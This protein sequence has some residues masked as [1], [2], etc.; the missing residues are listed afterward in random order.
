MQGPLLGR[1][2]EGGGRN[3]SAVIPS[4]LYGL[5]DA[6]GQPGAGLQTDKCDGRR[7]VCVCE[8]NVA[9]HHC[10]SEREKKGRGRTALGTNTRSRSWD[11]GSTTSSNKG[12]AG[13]ANRWAGLPAS[14][15]IESP[16]FSPP[17]SSGSW[18]RWGELLGLGR[19]RVGSREGGG[20]TWRA[21]GAD[22][23]SVPAARGGGWCGHAHP[24]H[25]SPVTL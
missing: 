18:E 25:Q 22:A 7:C 5:R 10:V 19:G 16:S 1:E 24:A 17:S 20:K 6:D 21:R 8:V 3:T 13:F 15:S 11:R 2:E 4:F 9:R 14:F 12:G 23:R